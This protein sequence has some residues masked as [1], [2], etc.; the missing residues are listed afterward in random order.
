MNGEGVES[1]CGGGDVLVITKVRVRGVI[2]QVLGVRLLL[3]VSCTF[4]VV[5]L[6]LRIF[7]GKVNGSV[8]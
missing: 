3:L 6:V 2:D 7:H 8:D 5:V 4:V 1:G